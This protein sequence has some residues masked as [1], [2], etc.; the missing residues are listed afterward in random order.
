MPVMA[1]E[2]PIHKPYDKAPPP[3]A[4]YEWTGVYIGVG[5]R[6]VAATNRPAR[7]APAPQAQPSLP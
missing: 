6:D 2:I 4:A 1:A 7:S 5:A 3:V